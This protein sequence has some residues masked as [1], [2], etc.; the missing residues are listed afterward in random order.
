M[1]GRVRTIGLLVVVV[2]LHGAHVHGADTLPPLE[3]GR[4]PSTLDELWKGYDPRAEPL[5]VEVVREWTE[6]GITYRALLY[7]V[8]TF[9]GRK[10]R[11]AAFYAFPTKHDGRLPAVLHLHGGGQRAFLRA[12]K[13]FADR[14]YA[15][16]SVNWGGREMERQQP[17]DPNTDWGAVDPT[18]NNVKGYFSMPPGPTSIDAV[19]SPRNNNWFLLTIGARRAIT[20]LERQPEV[21]PERIGVWG[22]SMGGRLTGLVTGA[23]ERVKVASPSVGGC[24][25]VSTDFPG[26]R[27]SGR[28]F[29]GNLGLFQK[30]LA[31]QA[32]LARVECPL[33]FLSATNDFNAPMDYVERGMELVPAKEKRTTY[34]VHLNHRFTPETD[35]SRV[36]WF[37]SHLQDRLTFPE[38]PAARLVLDGGDGV[39]VY[40]VRPDTS[41]AIERVAV[42]YGYDRDP[43]NRFWASAHVERT[44]DV[45]R[46]ACPVFDLDEPLFV[47]ANVSY[48]LNGDERP[49]GDPETFVLSVADAARPEALVDAGVRATEKPQRSI[50]DLSRGFTDW[51][52]L[53]AGNRHHWFFATRKLVDPRWSGPQGGRL[54]FDVTTDD[55]ANE[56]GVQIVTNAWR[57]YLGQRS[58]TFTARVPLVDAGRHAVELRPADFVDE[59]GRALADWDGITELVVRP[60]DTAVPGEESL[61][62]WNGSVPTFA[63]LRWVGGEPDERAKP[64]PPLETERN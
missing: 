60:A 56:L 16:L 29:N 63:D 33:L 26:I 3:N 36:L 23:D 22:H 44:G 15:A 18:Q 12:V 1:P 57:N 13:Q 42:Y 6:D 47:L 45:W 41:R 53:N 40:E 62:P 61:K 35:V 49:P 64:Y 30:T 37:D 52:A 51:Y 11:M 4:V 46:A 43:R 21:D 17:G 14:G 39:P 38:S 25:F 59:E 50:D 58:R 5:E 28:R 9:K 54:A 27:G 10:A 8:G 48:R 32:Y 20:F 31:G 55:D 2:Q 19:E 7:T 34:S 24:G